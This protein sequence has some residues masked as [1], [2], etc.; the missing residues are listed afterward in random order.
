MVPLWFY[1]LH[2]FADIAK[3]LSE[4]SLCY[5]A[6]CTRHY[7]QIILGFPELLPT[8]VSAKGL[9][10]REQSGFQLSGSAPEMYERYI[11]STLTA[12]LAQDLVTLAALKPGAQSALRADSWHIH[13]CLRGRLAG[14]VMHT[15]R[16]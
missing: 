12:A 3:T 11:V 13:P 4:T 15:C 7:R 9:S 14:R 2:T 8:S 5:D 1:T 10:M 6:D 16:V